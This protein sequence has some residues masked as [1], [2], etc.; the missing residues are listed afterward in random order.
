MPPRRKALPEAEALQAKRG[1]GR[2]TKLTPELQ[3]LFV[4]NL[5]LGLFWET[6][7]A[8]AGLDKGVAYGWV[9]RGKRAA[10][11][12]EKTGGKVSAA[13]LPFVNFST[14]VQQA[15]AQFDKVA[16]ASIL[17]AGQTDW[18]AMLALL[19]IRHPNWFT[20]DN[21]GIVIQTDER[22]LPDGGTEETT[23]VTV[24]GGA[25][26]ELDDDDYAIAARVLMRRRR[27]RRALANPTPKGDD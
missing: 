5:K 17:K 9:K 24:T 22:D 16:Q 11:E 7:C 23:T 14:A 13:D 1:R 19:K 15:V 27:E 20:A 12:A 21:P 26:D 3:A 6:T 25:A 8:L 2:P 18:K 10:Q 4:D